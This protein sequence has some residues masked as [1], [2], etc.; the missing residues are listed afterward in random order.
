MAT[1][2]GRRIGEP[3]VRRLSNYLRALQQARDAGYEHLS[4]E[5]LARASGTTAAQV[6]KDLS[7][8]GSFG[9]R[10]LGYPV[11][12]LLEHLRRILGLDRRWNVALIGAGRIGTALFGYPEFRRRGFEI[13]HVFD[14]DPAKVGQAWGSV[15][16]RHVDELE[17][18]LAQEPVE[19]AI[20]AVPAAAAQTVA[21]KAARAG[22]HAVLNF[23]PV[24]LRLPPRV[25][26]RNVNMTIELESL[27]F[28]L[29]NP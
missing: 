11:G 16:V 15:R 5:E 13:R 22:V 4:S 14:V 1:G 26:V 18:T 12:E 29:C 9:R 7:A 19:I 28:Q 21:E 17:V 20:L 25:A 23:A 3:T 6:R 24:P 8:L 10:G 2:V 27:C